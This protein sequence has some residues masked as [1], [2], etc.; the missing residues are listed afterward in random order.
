[1]RLPKPFCEFCHTEG[2][3]DFNEWHALVM[4]FGFPLWLWPFIIYKDR[5]KA[6]DVWKDEPWYAGIGMF[7]RMILLVILLKGVLL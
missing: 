1:M 4:G 6:F 2:K 7:L 3:F 5:S